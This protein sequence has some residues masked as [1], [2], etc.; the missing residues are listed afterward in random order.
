MFPEYIGTFFVRYSRKATLQESHNI[1]SPAKILSP[2]RDILI[3]SFAERLLDLSA[4]GVVRVL[5]Q[6]GEEAAPVGG[7]VPV[8]VID[9]G[10]EDILERKPFLPSR[11]SLYRRNPAARV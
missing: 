9:A 11:S 10:V 2:E 1:H 6:P 7:F 8:P 4:V 5:P 3:L